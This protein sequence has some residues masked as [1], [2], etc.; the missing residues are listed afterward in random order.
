M[1]RREFIHKTAIG[2]LAVSLPA[3]RSFGKNF[4]AGY[5]LQQ[6]VLGRTGQKVSAIAFGGI[7]L[8][9]NPQEF[10]NEIIAKAWDLGVNYYDIAPGYGDAQQK[11]GPAL[12]PYRNNC[13]L[14]CKTGRRDTKGAE[15]ELNDSLKKLQTDHFD[16][17][18]LHAINN[19]ER[20][21]ERA[22]AKDGAM[23]VFAK[24]K[25]D[26]KVRYLG[27]SAH[28]VPAALRALE[29]YDFDTVMFPINFAAWNAGDFGPQIYEA[30]RKRNLGIIA[31]KAMALRLNKQGEKKFDKNVWYQPV[32]DDDTQKMALKF[33]LSKKIA[34]AIPPGQSQMFLRALEIMKDYKPISKEDEKK[35]IALASNEDM[36]PVFSYKQS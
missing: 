16:L 7:L 36:E 27:F 26:G 25:K 33:S 24:A 28:S 20:D 15:E 18:Q 10:A 8:N 6:R 23:E 3:L 1:Q 29:L 11:M 22:F 13:F 5:S 17:Y 31:L 19:V 4:P 30:A 21:V 12:K 2:S 34:T 32:Q 35:L 9:D 14:A